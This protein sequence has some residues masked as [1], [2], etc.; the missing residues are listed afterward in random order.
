MSELVAFCL[1]ATAF[2]TNDVPKITSNTDQLTSTNQP[3]L[4][5]ASHPL[6]PASQ[7]PSTSQL[8]TSASQPLT[9]TSQ[10]LAPAGQPITSSQPL[11]SINQPLTSANQLL[12]S[13]SQ[14]LTSINQ[15]LTSINRPLTSVSQSLASTS[16]PLASINQSFTMTSQPLASATSTSQPVQDSSFE[17]GEFQGSSTEQ[18]VGTSTSDDNWASFE[19]AFNSDVPSST[20]PISQNTTT[21]EAFAAATTVSVS[22]Y[23]SGPGQFAVFDEANF[24]PTNTSA[25]VSNDDSVVPNHPDNKYSVF[26]AVRSDDPTASNTGNEDSEFGQFEMGQPPTNSQ[27]AVKVEHY[28]TQVSYRMSS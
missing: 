23:T 13:T 20:Q 15:P 12:A 2:P 10:P 3:L 18:Q 11:S 21:K 19:S 8:L 17:F 7:P 24:P 5:S 27:D 28:S 26:D 6:M 22:T 4:A 9:L 14:P 1:V 16:Q 25:P